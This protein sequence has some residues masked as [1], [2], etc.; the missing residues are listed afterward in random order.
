[1]S[2]ARMAVRSTS[3]RPNEKEMAEDE[4]AAIPAGQGAEHAAVVVHGGGDVRA[5]RKRNKRPV[6]R[7]GRKSGAGRAR[8]GR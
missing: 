5:R 6:E 1:M 3:A 7:A 4:P 8:A 2:P